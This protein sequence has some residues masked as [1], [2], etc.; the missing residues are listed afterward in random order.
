MSFE[1]YF[2]DELDYLRQLGRDAAIERPHLAAF[3]SE[4]GSDPDVERFAG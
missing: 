2:R 4:Q 1:K 3:L